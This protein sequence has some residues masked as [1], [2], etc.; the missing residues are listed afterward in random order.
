MTTFALDLPTATY[1]DGP[2]V[3]RFYDKLAAR[4]RQAP[5][6]AGVAVM[7]GLPP[8]RDA[9]DTDTDIDGYEKR[10]EE[11]PIANVDHYQ[12]ASM[13]YFETMGIPIVTAARSNWP[14]WRG[15]RRW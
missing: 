14:T 8:N 12:F 1:G 15:G 3:E 4:L 5:G 9:N 11:D 13:G 6:V 2:G 7:S 10:S